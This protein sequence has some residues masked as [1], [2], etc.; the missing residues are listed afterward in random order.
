MR[1]GPGSEW[2]DRDGVNRLYAHSAAPKAGW[3]VYVGEDESAVLASVTQ[4]RKRQLELIGIGLLILLLAVAFIYRNVASP[5]RRLS[6]AVREATQRHEPEP[7]PISGPTEMRAL[8]EDVNVLAASVHAELAER[9][10]AEA[11]ARASET[12]YRLLFQDNPSPMYVYDL[13]GGI[14]VA[15]NDTALALYGYARDEFIGMPVEDLIA[16]AEM[17]RLRST[18][19]NLRSGLR[20]GLSNSGIWSH[21][22]SDGSELE[23]EITATDHVFDGRAARVVLAFDVTERVEAERLIRVSE[24]RYRD[25]F[26]NASDLIATVDLDGRVTDVNEAF[27][28]STGYSR[29]ELLELRLERPDSGGVARGPR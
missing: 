8:A 26:E 7:V 29:E 9:G 18:V 5:I 24:A 12:S 1:P 4:L 13:E 15:V 22:R 3:N 25:L 27:L 11:A 28:R 6:A 17:A 23:V 10:R 2:R 14:L 20:S 21:R 16:P 19:G